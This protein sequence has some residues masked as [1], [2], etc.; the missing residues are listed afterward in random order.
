MICE[1]RPKSIF[2]K[3]M[4]F[5]HQ[6]LCFRNNDLKMNKKIIPEEIVEKI[7]SYDV[8][9]N[10]E[11]I[12]AAGLK[13]VFIQKYSNILK[14]NKDESIDEFLCSWRLEKLVSRGL[15]KID[16]KLLDNLP[17]EIWTRLSMKR[18]LKESFIIRNSQNLNLAMIKHFKKGEFSHRF[19][20]ALPKFREM[21]KCDECFENDVIQGGLCLECLENTCRRCGYVE[22]PLVYDNFGCCSGCAGCDQYN[23][24]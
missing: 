15:N 1:L 6:K 19:H 4:I 8:Y 10:I 14:F 11:I 23:Y 18:Y 5:N 24:W 9:G 20:E 21:T 12:I 17:K 2:V 22:H 16:Q 7:L 13:N 3:N